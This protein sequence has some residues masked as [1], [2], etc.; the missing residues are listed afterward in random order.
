MAT[1]SKGG[2]LRFGTSRERSVRP[3]TPPVARQLGRADLPVIALLL[4]AGSLDLEQDH[5]CLATDARHLWPRLLSVTL[6]ALEE[7]TLEPHEILVGRRP[8]AGVGERRGGGILSLK[9]VAGIVYPLQETRR[10]VTS[11][12]HV[13]PP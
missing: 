1:I 5:V 4:E 6:T 7:V 9:A 2:L 10:D 12:L 3:T 13:P 8:A 11:I